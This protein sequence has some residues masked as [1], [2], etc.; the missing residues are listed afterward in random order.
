MSIVPDVE[1]QRARK[2]DDTRREMQL[3][4]DQAAVAHSI[5]ED[6]E[7]FLEQDETMEEAIKTCLLCPGL[8]GVLHLDLEGTITSLNKETTKLLERFDGKNAPWW[9]Q[10]AY[11][12]CDL[13]QR[14]PE[15]WPGFDKED[16]R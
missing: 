11:W 7:E 3:D 10:V 15:E 2:L 12:W 16:W 14:T 6:F 8:K 4:A 1:K 5:R 9:T 13:M